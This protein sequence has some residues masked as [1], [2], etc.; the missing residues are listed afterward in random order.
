MAL[1]HNTKIINADNDIAAAQETKREAFTKYFP[2]VSAS[3]NAY[4]ANKPL[5]EISMG[6]LGSMKLLKDGI[7]GG[8]TLVQPVF[9]GGQIVNANRLAKVGVEVSR[10]QRQQNVNNVRLTVERYFW[11]VVVLKEKIKTVSVVES[12]L[13]NLNK[14]VA[15][16][17]N[18]GVR[19]RNDLLQVQ[20]KQND[21]ASTRLNLENNLAVCRLL[22]GQCIG[23]EGEADAEASVPALP[24]LGGEGLPKYREPAVALLST[25]EYRLL[26]SNVEAERLQKNLALGKNLPSVGIGTGYMYDNLMDKSHSFALG[27]VSVSVPLSGWWGGSHDIKK[28]KLQLQ[29]AQNSL[30]DNGQLLRI[31]IQKAWNDLDNSWQQTKIADLSIAQSEENLRLHNDYYKAGTSTMSDLLD[32]QTLY[33]QAR[34]KYVD[35]FTQY[36]LKQT[37]YLI[38]VG[39]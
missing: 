38:A 20:L 15:A 7:M 29:N 18:A 10:L 39:E 33:Q 4:N 6:Q 2:T 9:A 22:L 24:E 21:M 31:R 36:Q 27:F 5:A 34:D 30:K 13:Q 28:H 32:A 1:S 12:M 11:Q 37:E 17:V 14:D 19:N 16:A 25:P 26:Q 35:S 23:A 3:G 8:V